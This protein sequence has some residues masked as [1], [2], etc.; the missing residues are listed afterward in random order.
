MFATGYKIDFMLVTELVGNK[1]SE[2][3]SHT[4][5]SKKTYVHNDAFKLLK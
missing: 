2:I 1:G 4:A 5:D 3:A